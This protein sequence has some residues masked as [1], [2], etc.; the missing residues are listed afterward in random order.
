MASPYLL[1]EWNGR[2]GVGRCGTGRDGVG[3][4]WMWL[5]GAGRGWMVDT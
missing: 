1:C 2:N 3:R 5:D 4:G